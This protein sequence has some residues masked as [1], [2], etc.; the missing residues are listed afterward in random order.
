[1]I[2][3]YSAILTVLT[4]LNICLKW[5]PPLTF[6]GILKPATYLGKN[7]TTDVYVVK[8]KTNC[9]SIK[10][11]HHLLLYS[12]AGSLTDSQ[13]NKQDSLNRYNNHNFLFCMQHT[14]I[15]SSPWSFK[16]SFAYKIIRTVTC[17][18]YQMFN[19]FNVYTTV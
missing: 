12:K 8:P 2:S 4:S 18:L 16:Q 6:P 17:F 19:V 13:W 15:N 10:G 9:F 1:M 11:L 14:V 7:S 3:I 5:T